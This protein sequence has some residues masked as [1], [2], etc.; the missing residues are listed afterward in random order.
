MRDLLIKS[1]WFK[2]FSNVPDDI[3][4]I[5]FSRIIRQGCFEE[6]IDTS[7]DGENWGLEVAWGEIQG[8]IQRMKEAK[9]QKQNYGKIHG[10]KPAA[11]EKE[12]YEYIQ[13]HPSAK[14]AEIGSA[15]GLEAGYSS[16]GPY[17][18][19]YDMQVWK[20][21]KKITKDV[22]YEEFFGKNDSEFRF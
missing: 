9:E 1:D 14:V 19:V 12:I 13:E 4:D 18:Y 2:N 5:I 8:N 22:S 7:K 10:R 3:K 6:E 15:L 16:K 21:R 20:D 11:N 17:A